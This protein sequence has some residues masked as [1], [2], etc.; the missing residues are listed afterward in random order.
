MS[1]VGWCVAGCWGGT[2]SSHNA[3]PHQTTPHRTPT[4]YRVVHGVPARLV[5]DHA[6]AVELQAAVVRL[7]QHRD[8]L[9]RD[10]RH[11]L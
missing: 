10:E 5:V 6:A 7:H 1:N 3:T 2:G 8:R 9:H 11:E 4:A